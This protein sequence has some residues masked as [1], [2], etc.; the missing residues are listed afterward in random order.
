MDRAEL[1]RRVA[2]DVAAGGGDL[3]EALR[4]LLHACGRSR[5]ALEQARQRCRELASEG[6]DDATTRR[7]LELLDGALRTD[8]YAPSS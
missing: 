3:E 4:Q 2:M 6:G 8:V 1:A 5:D 7:A